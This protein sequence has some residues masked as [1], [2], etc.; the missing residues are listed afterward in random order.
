M[1]MVLFVQAW[2]LRPSIAD[3]P[4]ETL[5]QIMKH[6][7]VTYENQKHI[8]WYVPN[9]DAPVSETW[10][11]ASLGV[12]D[13]GERRVV[14]NIRG[15]NGDLWYTRSVH[16]ETDGIV[17]NIRLNPVQHRIDGH[18]TPSGIDETLLMDDQE[19]VIRNIANATRASITLLGGKS[20]GKQFS[21]SPRDLVNFR[22]IILLSDA[23]TLPTAREAAA[24]GKE[25]GRSGPNE[26]RVLTNPRLIENS[27]KLPVYPERARRVGAQGR[28][29]LYAV[30]YKDGSVGD[31]RVARTPVDGVGFEKAAL[32]A[33]KKW[34]YE[35]GL[36]DGT[37]VD[38]YFT[39]VVD[40]HLEH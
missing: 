15:L 25:R 8:T 29:I 10:I 40:F 3:L 28:V 24:Q 2:G 22:R 17:R 4:E 32:R 11:Y 35:P 30:V 39:I 31:L 27:K 12:A 19:N 37:P 38:V 34:R 36:L 23:A 5:D 33:V 18:S 21:L 13:E 14:L 7:S 20:G 1:L 26:S 9:H 6:V 16:V